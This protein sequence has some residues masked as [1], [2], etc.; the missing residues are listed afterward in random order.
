VC[1]VVIHA[2][3]TSVSDEQRAPGVILATF[4]RPTDLSISQRTNDEDFRSEAIPISSDIGSTHSNGCIQTFEF[5][6]DK[7]GFHEQTEKQQSVRLSELPFDGLA[8]VWH[9]RE[10]I[11]LPI[12]WISIP[13]RPQTMPLCFS[14]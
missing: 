14:C 3:S 12:R 4:I 5:R 9:S 1:R 7:G 2:F 8:V 11:Q 6:S 13:M 10:I